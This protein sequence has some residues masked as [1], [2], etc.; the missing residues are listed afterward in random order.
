MQTNCPSHL[1]CRCLLKEL[2]NGVHTELNW[3]K[4]YY[5]ASI[6]FFSFVLFEN[7]QEELVH[8][9]LTKKNNLLLSLNF[10]KSSISQTTENKFFMLARMRASFLLSFVGLTDYLK[11]SGS[12]IAAY[13]AH[14]R[15]CSFMYRNLLSLLLVLFRFPQLSLFH[16]DFF[17]FSL[18]LLV[19]RMF[20]NQHYSYTI[21]TYKFRKFVVVGTV[22]SC[23]PSRPLTS[24]YITP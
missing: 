12:S 21:C 3:N 5:R 16:I 7:E 1:I 17:L 19:L 14:L 23:K 11:A 15:S 22:A 8:R 24:I 4:H 9:Q 2:N 18:F 20:D 6:T 13:K 10:Q